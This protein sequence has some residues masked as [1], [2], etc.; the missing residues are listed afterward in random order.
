M[1]EEWK[2]VVGYEGRYEVSD[3]G[4]V[5]SF[6]G[7]GSAGIQ[8]ESHLLTPRLHTG[9]YLRVQLDGRDYYIHRLVLETFVGP[10]PKGFEC[11]HGPNHTQ[12]DNRLCNL[13]WGSR[14]DNMVDVVH[15]GKHN[16]TR[17]NS[18]QARIIRRCRELNVK[19]SFL[20]EIFGIARGI[21]TDVACGRTWSHA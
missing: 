12:T 4:R 14:S 7:M 10:C 5:C 20:S 3:Q 21:I 18:V 2:P 17:I 19:S 11:C 8:R 1:N 16:T 9:G 15:N 13:R 6:I